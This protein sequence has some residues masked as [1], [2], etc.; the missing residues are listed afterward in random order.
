MSTYVYMRLLEST[1]QRYDRGIRLLSL[2]GIREMYEQAAA[3]AVDGLSAP[4]VLEIGCGTGSLT[5]E[6]VRRGARVTAI[7]QDAAMLEIARQKIG[8]RA[9]LIEMAAVEI[10]DRFPPAS[11]DAV[12]STLALS[13]MSED[14]QAFVLDAAR[15][16][17]RPDGRLVVADEVLPEGILGRVAHAFW[18][19]PLAAATWLLTQTSTR[20]VRDLAGLVRR[21]G[22]VD[23]EQRPL[24]R[25]GVRLV[26]GRRASQEEA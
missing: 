19:L 3:A 8:D 9:E 12:A 7:D 18:R 24:R 5:A 20:A 15:R 2:G 4:R 26:Q 22:F 17:L 6:L 14:E 16:V 25:A 23:V 10:A 21:A 11:F 13:E 1:P